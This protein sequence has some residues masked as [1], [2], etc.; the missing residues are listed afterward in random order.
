MPQI[1]KTAAKAAAQA[2]LVILSMCG[3]CQLPPEVKNWIERWPSL[4]T[5][6]NPAV[7][8]LVENHQPNCSATTWTLSYLR[9]VADRYGL[10]LFTQR[11]GTLTISQ[12]TP[13][14][15]FNG[16]KTRWLHNWDAR[17]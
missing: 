8:V 15:A 1:K 6:S 4:I 11:T 12:N 7:A 17:Y 10:S 2:D 9:S 16:A 5:D 14:A 13:K 3:K